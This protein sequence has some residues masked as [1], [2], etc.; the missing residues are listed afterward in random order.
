M[1]LP[2]ACQAAKVPTTG[3]VGR[4]RQERFSSV[5]V[6]FSPPLWGCAKGVWT[7]KACLKSGHRK[8][9][10]QESMIVIRLASILDGCSQEGSNLIWMEANGRFLS[11][12]RHHPRT[13]G[14]VGVD[15]PNE[16]IPCQ[17]RRRSHE[18]DERFLTANSLDVRPAAGRAD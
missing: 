11:L 6:S 1:S 2:R 7:V 5:C 14:E 4:G 15:G 9:T 18:K 3:N 17:S 8:R 13:L 12:N 10:R 16:A